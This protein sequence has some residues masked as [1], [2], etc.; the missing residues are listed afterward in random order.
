ML[1]DSEST[2]EYFAPENPNF[3][4]FTRFAQLRFAGV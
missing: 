2:V 1:V 4:Q 3:S